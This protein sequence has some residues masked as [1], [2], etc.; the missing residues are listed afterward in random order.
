MQPPDVQALRSLPHSQHTSAKAL[1]LLEAEV[2]SDMTDQAMTNQTEQSSS[3]QKL[4]ANFLLSL[5]HMAENYRLE[6]TLFLGKLTAAHGV[7]GGTGGGAV[8]HGPESPGLAQPSKKRRLGMLFDSCVAA[9]VCGHTFS[10]AHRLALHL[11][12]ALQAI[13]S[14]VHHLISGCKGQVAT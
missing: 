2:L 13:E 10:P 5:G 11:Y 1:K 7:E 12:P 9:F 3:W 14:W 6:R 4:T 8:A